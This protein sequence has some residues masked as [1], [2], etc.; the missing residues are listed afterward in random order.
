[1]PFTAFFGIGALVLTVGSIL[2]WGWAG[3]LVAIGIVLL[4]GA[5]GG[6]AV[7]EIVSRLNK[8]RD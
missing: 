7:E 8:D 5:I 6:M 2:V 3:L 4:V 1:M